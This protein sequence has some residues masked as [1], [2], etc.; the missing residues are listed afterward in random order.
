M[1]KNSFFIILL[2]ATITVDVLSQRW[3]PAAQIDGAVLNINIITLLDGTTL[4]PLTRV[5]PK[6]KDTLVFYSVESLLT[7]RKPWHQQLQGRLFLKG[8]FDGNGN[9]YPEAIF[10]QVGLPSFF[11]IDMFSENMTTEDLPREGGLSP[12]PEQTVEYRGNLDGDRYV[13]QIVATR[14]DQFAWVVYG[15]SLRPLLDYSIVPAN[16]QRANEWRARI[17]AVGPLS[18]KMCMVQLAFKADDYDWGYYQLLEL[19]AEDLRARRDTIRTTLLNEVANPGQYLFDSKILKADTVWHFFPG[20][21]SADVPSLK[22]KLQSIT[23]QPSASLVRM[24]DHSY[25]YGQG[26]VVGDWSFPVTMSANRLMVANMGVAPGDYQHLLRLFLCSDDDN[27][28]LTVFADAYL[29]IASDSSWNVVSAAALIQDN[30]GDGIEDLVVSHGWTD[31]ET[32]EYRRAVSIFLT[33]QIEPVSVDESVLN[34]EKLDASTVLSARRMENAW[35]V[36]DG[37]R[38][39]RR[40]LAPVY[41]LRGQ[42]IAT[43]RTEVNGDDVLLLD[44]GEITERPAWC[45]VGTCVIRLY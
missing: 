44:N 23:I 2:V 22:V 28:E 41:D 40:D 19:N 1:R 43:V 12:F 17:L 11:A 31:P 29:P 4:I 39:V 34:L 25:W 9:G 18:G 37:A 35:I 15:D 21:L 6:Q 14:D 3:Q 38:C 16:Y 7:D 8:V 10:G 13:D 36:P 45:V 5:V 20:G 26:K 27:A 32:K 42:K 30:D 24:G 33:T